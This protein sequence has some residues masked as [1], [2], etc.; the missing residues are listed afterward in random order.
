MTENSHS[1]LLDILIAPERFLPILPGSEEEKKEEGEGHWV[2]PW[3]G[4][5]R[6]CG[7]EEG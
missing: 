5:M 3:A 7:D 4:Q 2:A 1:T 6:Y